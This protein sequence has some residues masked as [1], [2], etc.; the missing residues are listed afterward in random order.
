M[1]RIGCSG[2]SYEHWRGVLY[3]RSG[4]S[5]RWL[6]IYAQSFDTVEINATFYRLPA[7][8]V[9]EGWAKKRRSG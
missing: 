7:V 2:W 1:I 6:E 5:G 4:S 9:V 8:G 3:P